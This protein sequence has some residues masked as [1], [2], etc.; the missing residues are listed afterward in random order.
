M[1]VVYRGADNDIHELYW[2]NGAWSVNDLTATTGAPAAAGDPNGFAFTANG[3]SGMH[4]V[5]RGADDDIHELYWQN[6]AWGVND[7]TAAT[8]APPAAGDP[9]GYAFTANGTSGMH[10]VYRGTDN[11]IHEL[12]WENGGW[13]LNDL[14]AGTNA[15]AAAGDPNG[16]VFD[17]QE[18]MHVVYPSADGHIDEFWRAPA[19]I[20]SAARTRAVKPS[21]YARGAMGKAPAEA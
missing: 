6:G 8:N 14:T 4:V 9:N 19:S 10:V 2:Q 15:P 16:Y 18:Q 1:H 17:A 7:L 12:Y 21:R 13:S 3:T 11:D 20:S 5:H